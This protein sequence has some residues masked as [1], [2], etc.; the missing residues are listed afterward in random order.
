MP[1][2]L[3]KRVSALLPNGID[4]S[5]EEAFLLRIALVTPRL[6]GRGGIAR[7]RAC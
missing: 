2:K 5:I 3:E 1:R 6:I 7:Y 4:Q